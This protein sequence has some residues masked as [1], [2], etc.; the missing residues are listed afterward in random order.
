MQIKLP[1]KSKVEESKDE[2]S[3]D[4]KRHLEKKQIK[5]LITKNDDH[6][7]PFDSVMK[8]LVTGKAMSRFVRVKKRN[9]FT[10]GFM[11]SGC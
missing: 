5:Y 9:E 10:D 3:I 2:M 8:L 6:L 4:Q 1:K 11:I 7:I